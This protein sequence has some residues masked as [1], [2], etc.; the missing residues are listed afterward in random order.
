MTAFR[1]L[2][3]LVLLTTSLAVAPAAADGHEVTDHV[4]ESHDGTPIAITVYRPAG[5][6][7]DD[8]VPVILHS[9][10]WSGTRTSSPT[11]F[12]RELGRGFGVVS[13]DQRAHGDSGGTTRV[14]DPDYEGRDIVAVIDY[15]ASLDWVLKDTDEQGNPIPDDPVLFA[16]GGSYG[17]GYQLVGA[18][19][20]LRDNGR[21]RFNAL[22]PEITWFNLAEALAPQGVVRTAWVSALY[23]VGIPM[24]EEDIHVAFAFGA[25]TGQWPDGTVPA[26]PNIDE[27]FRRNGPSGFV[28][29][30]LQLDIPVLVGQGT[31]DN[32][33][34]LNQGVEIFEQA[35]TPQAREQSALIA[36]NGGHVLP[37]ALPLAY[38]A[39]GDACSG[40]GGF[41][42]LRLRFFEAVIAG[43][44]P[45]ELTGGFAH[46]LTT[47]DGDCVR[48][49]SLEPNETLATGYDVQLTS[50][51]AT[52]TGAGAPHHLELAEGPLT[53][54]GVPYL[55]ARVTTAGVDQRVFF[56]LS[57]GETP[58]TAQVV[59]NNVMPLREFE[60]IIQQQRV[61]E[62]PG[63]AV[64]VPEGEFLYLTVSPVSDMFGGHGSTRTPGWIGMENLQV[65]VPI[66]AR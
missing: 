56:A 53:V 22:A 46:N 45:R 10:G 44:D 36:Y 33:F 26:V 25:G 49:D 17:G 30:G 59:Q 42:E 6:D 12:G 21:V 9:H 4:V 50:G 20:D 62:L 18:F 41:G 34:N 29:D 66:V 48:V 14:Q 3:V 16:I 39:D 13:I 19:T 7:A 60:P 57:V 52:T 15:V 37:N 27:R 38:A 64:D 63:V 1:P 55:N 35:L 28:A 61:I 43:E 54:A 11:S 23:A 2:A 24:F 65:D 31:S 47:A 58:A 8:P 5:A 40:E 51:Y 32:L